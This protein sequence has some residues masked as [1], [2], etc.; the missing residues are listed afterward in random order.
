MKLNSQSMKKLSKIKN[1]LYD[2]LKV[3]FLYHSNHLEGSTFSIEA[4]TK[5]LMEKK[6][7]GIYSLDDIIET[8]NSLEVFDKVVSDSDKTLDKYM[9]FDWH[10][11]LKKGTV[12][13]EIHNAGVWKQY[14]NKLKN[15]DLK[16]ASPLEVDNLMLNLL[17]DWTD[18]SGKNTIKDIAK[19]HAR[20]EHIHPFQYD[21][22]RIG[23]FIILKQC[24][25]ENIDL[26]AID[27]EY[28]KQYKEA[29]YT[30]Q[31][32]DNYEPLISVFENC[33]KRLDY[34]LSDISSVLDRI[35]NE[36]SG[37]NH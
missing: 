7:E 31:T 32:T 12:D 36:T 22:G 4:L 10:K 5:L 9:L 19:F 27:E 3:E 23:R 16:V 1:S 29:L 17:L 2:D 33:Q 28:E 8:R 14:E 20:F 18:H 6:I 35:E 37:S 26:I 30:A 25:E 24:L 13:D 15:V 11:T 21:N 34:K